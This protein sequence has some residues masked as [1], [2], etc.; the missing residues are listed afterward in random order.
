[1]RSGIRVRDLRRARESLVRVVKHAPLELSAID[2]LIDHVK[3]GMSET[4]I[5]DDMGMERA[6]VIRK[7]I[8]RLR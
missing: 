2:I 4:S 3:M 5:F 6:I 8:R 7:L 1:M